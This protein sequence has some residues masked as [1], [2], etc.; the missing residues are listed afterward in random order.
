MRKQNIKQILLYFLF[1]LLFL[2]PKFDLYL[3]SS[4]SLLI[5]S[6]SLLLLLLFS[7]IF[8]LSLLYF[9]I[10]SIILAYIEVVSLQK[11]HTSKRSCMCS[12]LCFFPFVHL[13]VRLPIGANTH[14]TFLVGISP[15]YF[16]F[17][18]LWH[19]NAWLTF[20][21]DLDLFHFSVAFLFLAN[22]M[23]LAFSFSKLFSYRFFRVYVPEVCEIQTK[24]LDEKVQFN[25]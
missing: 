19:D 20:L 5:C 16:T 15:L 2:S 10:S 7:L 1:D 21:I 22:N 12:T 24:G 25:F 11:V 3:F 9:C 23:V 6:I 8:S 18:L 4:D 14:A 13:H 17:T